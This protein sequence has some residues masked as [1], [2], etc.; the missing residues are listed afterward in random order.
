MVPPDPAVVLSGRIMTEG[1]SSQR[2]GS[3]GRKLVWFFSSV[4]RTLTIPRVPV[5]SALHSSSAL[6]VDDRVEAGDSR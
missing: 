3:L 1:F 2:A 6:P 4:R 5:A